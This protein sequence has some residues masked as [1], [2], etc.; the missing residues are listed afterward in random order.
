MIGFRRLFNMLRAEISLKMGSLA[1]VENWLEEADLPA[2]PEDDPAREMEYVIKA[3]YLVD[4]GALDEASRL[5]EILESYARRS[6]RVRVLISTL[7]NKATLE[8]KKGELGKVKVYLEEALALAV[9]QGYFRLLLDSGA[10]LLGLLAQMP[11][12]KLV[13]WAGRQ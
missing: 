11:G 13:A 6:R 8:W 3:R 2:I 9:P 1:A 12:A 7:L 4:I 5:L 10:L